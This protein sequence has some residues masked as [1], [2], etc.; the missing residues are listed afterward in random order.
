LGTSLFLREVYQR[1]HFWLLERQLGEYD[2]SGDSAENIRIADPIDL[3]KIVAA[4]PKELRGN[5][6]DRYLRKKIAGRFSGGYP[7][8]ISERNGRFE[9]AVWCI[10]F[11]VICESQGLENSECAFEICNLFV[12]PECRMKGIGTQLLEQ[13]LV[14]MARQ[15]KTVAYSRILPERRSSLDLHFS[16]GFHLS[17]IL[18]CTTIFGRQRN[19]IVPLTK[20]RRRNIRGLELPPCVLLVRGAWGGALEAIRSLGLRGVQVYVFVLGRDPTPYIKSRYCREAIE[21]TG[22]DAVSMRL[23]LIAWYKTQRFTRRPLLV[24]MIDILATF[25]AEER[26]SLEECFTIGAARPQTILDLLDKIRANSLA[27]NHGLTVPKSM[28]VRSCN[29]LQE[30]ATTLNYPVI[31]KPTWWREKGRIDF[32]TATFDTPESLVNGLSIVLDGNS[33]ALVQSYIPGKDQDIEAFMFYRDLRGMVWACTSRKLRQSPPGAGIM[34]AG[35]AEDIPEL[36]DLCVRFLNKID[37]KG[38]GGIEFKIERGRRTYIE[39]SVRPEGFHAL[40]RKAGVDLMWVA[41]CDYCLGGLVEIPNDQHKA[42]YLDWHAYYASYGL[43]NLVQW[44]IG[45]LGMF[46]KRP[47]KIAVFELRDPG[48]SLY[49]IRRKLRERYYRIIRKFSRKNN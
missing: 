8:V 3:E 30:A 28:I 29:E 45:V 18:Y 15:G 7:C 31:A 43:R 36:R 5:H 17:G 10:P 34:A 25:V 20:A 33:S 13:A 35:I 19:C 38:L 39:T 4:W 48:P 23:E 37:Y 21:L 26:Q 9:G 6:S 1:K 22:K 24:P 46:T 40:S 14:L 12:V 49:L 41:Y 44:S 47:L 27:A 11:N 32:K 42:F 2:A 16:C